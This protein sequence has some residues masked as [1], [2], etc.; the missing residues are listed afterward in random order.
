MEGN[1]PISMEILLDKLIAIES[2]MG[3]NFSNLDT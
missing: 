2:R 1:S 3:D